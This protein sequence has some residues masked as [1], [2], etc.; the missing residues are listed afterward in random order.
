MP[1]RELDGLVLGSGERARRSLHAQRGLE[2]R[3]AQFRS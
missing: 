3:G 1:D 2:R